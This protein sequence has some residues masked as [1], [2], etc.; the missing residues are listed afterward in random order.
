MGL[1]VDLNRVAATQEFLEKYHIPY[2]LIP[3]DDKSVKME[4]ER[5]Y[6][7]FTMIESDVPPNIRQWMEQASKGVF[8]ANNS[9]KMLL[10]LTI[11]G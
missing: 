11:N 6:G 10:V 7:V 2:K 5:I 1:S 9:D 3:L 8:D 4:T